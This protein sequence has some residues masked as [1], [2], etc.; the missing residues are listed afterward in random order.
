MSRKD[1]LIAIFGCIAV[2]FFGIAGSIFV[3]ILPAIPIALI[4]LIV[5]WLFF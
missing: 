2:V 1:D 3:A 4:I 5:K